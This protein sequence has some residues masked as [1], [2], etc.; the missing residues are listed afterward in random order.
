MQVLLGP[1]T[2]GLVGAV[3]LF[4]LAAL[5]RV[6]LLLHGQFLVFANYLL[7]FAYEIVCVAVTK[8]LNRLLF[9]GMLLFI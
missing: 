3:G 1:F 4:Q 8:L 5:P 9:V 6:I 2:Q 7:L